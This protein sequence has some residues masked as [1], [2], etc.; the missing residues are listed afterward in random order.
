M[1]RIK[2]GGRVEKLESI[3]CRASKSKKRREERRLEWLV[4]MQIL[5]TKLPSHASK[6]RT[7][8]SVANR[9]ANRTNWTASK[10]LDFPLPF[11][12]RTQFVVDANG[13]ISGCWRKDRKLDIVICLM[14]IIDVRVVVSVLF[15]DEVWTGSVDLSSTETEFSTIEVGDHK[16]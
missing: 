3:V 8:L 6:K 5:C 14:C 9:G 2:R 16:L 12:P 11:L 4:A 15:Y 1:G 13:L 7:D 10:R